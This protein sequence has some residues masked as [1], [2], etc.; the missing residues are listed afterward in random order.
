MYNLFVTQKIKKI[1]FT[2]AKKIK[3]E[4]VGLIKNVQF[5]LITL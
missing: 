4:V 3:S 2:F 1:I 5:K